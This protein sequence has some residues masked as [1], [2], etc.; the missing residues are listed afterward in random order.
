MRQVLQKRVNAYVKEN[1]DFDKGQTILWIEDILQDFIR[2]KYLDD[3]RFAELK[4]RAYL[5]A[6]KPER[7]I[8][9]KLKQKGISE[10]IINEILHQQEYDIFQMA[11][12]LAKKKKIGPYRE[13]EKRREFYQKDMGVLVRAG[14]DYDVVQEILNYE[15][16]YEEG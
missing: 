4:I 2:L 14:F 12:R 15:S 8:K 3:R 1:P 6:G 16:K 13:K 10:Q 11:L 5:N 7:Y 9:P